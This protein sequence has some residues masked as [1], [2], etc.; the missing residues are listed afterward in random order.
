AQLTVYKGMALRSSV[1]YKLYKYNNESVTSLFAPEK[2]PGGLSWSAQTEFT[3]M[4]QTLK[5]PERTGS[6]RRQMGFAGD[7]NVRVK[8][9]R[10]RLRLDLSFRD[11]GFI[12]HSQP[13]LPPYSD[14]PDD[15][16]IKPN[17][18]AAVGIDK[19]WGDWL[20]LG[21]IG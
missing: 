8:I 21:I 7:L 4:G 2:Y 10:V 20:T 12:L 14:F 3:A 1:D 16:E 6:T 5:D 17:Y 9:D 18:F 19:N 11:L 15:Y 13:S